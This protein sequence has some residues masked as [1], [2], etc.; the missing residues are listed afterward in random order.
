MASAALR[1]IIENAKGGSSW[2]A[3]A[4]KLV[5]PMYSDS[6]PLRQWAAQ[7]DA[8]N[9]DGAPTPFQEGQNLINEWELQQELRKKREELR[10]K[11]LTEEDSD[12]SPINGS[13][14][15]TKAEQHLEKIEQ[16]TAKM[17]DVFSQT[18]F[19]GGEA[20]RRGLSVS[21]MR[22]MNGTSSRS[23]ARSSSAILELDRII[24]ELVRVEMARA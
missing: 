6:N 2:F 12:A 24:R 19:G 22:Q 14:S 8:K 3:E 4:V 10:K 5:N 7:Q 20:L 18:A 13:L 21:D 1:N 23:G 11:K 17:V 15:A 16:H 9:P